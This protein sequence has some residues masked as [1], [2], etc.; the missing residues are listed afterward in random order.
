MTYTLEQISEISAFVQRHKSELTS[1]EY[2]LTKI[3]LN[4]YSWYLAEGPVREFDI[5]F[6]NQIINL[7]LWNFCELDKGNFIYPADWP[8][9][10]KYS[11]ESGYE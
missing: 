5:D 2:Q 7:V 3:T 8:E 4:E 11:L 9:F 10:C 6:Y 1:L